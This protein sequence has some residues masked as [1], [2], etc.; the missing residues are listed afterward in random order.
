MQ[1]RTAT[2]CFK[3]FLPFAALIL[4]I[5]GLAGTS[6]PAQR[7]LKRHAIPQSLRGMLIPGT[8]DVQ[9]IVEL[10]DP[11]VLDRLQGTAP[12][13][14][15]QGNLPL[16]ARG[17]KVDFST[18]MARTHRGAVSRGQESMKVKIA[19]IPD[20][21]I[22]GTTSALM[23][24]VIIR[25]PAAQYDAVRNITGIKKVYF[26]LPRKPLLDTAATLQRAQA[27]WT[28]AG[29]KSS[30]G[31]G[32]RIGIL[33][34][35]IDITSPM[36]SGTGMTAPSG[37]P[38]Y[39]P[40]TNLPF[41]NAKV[42]VA[43]S[44]SSLF[45]SSSG[46]QTVEDELGHGTFVASCAAGV[47]VNAPK[48]V[49]SGMAPGAYLGVYKILSTSSTSSAAEIAALDD[50]ILDGMDVI[51]M[52]IGA[53][54]HLPPDEIVEYVALRKAIQ[55][56]VVVTISAG[57]EGASTHTISSPA[58]IPDVIAVGSVTNSRAF[59][60]V[61][62]TNAPSLTTIGYTPSD[63]TPVTSDQALKKIVDVAS[64]DADG[65]GCAAFSSG[66]LTGSIA[67]IQRGICNF[68]V[69]VGN[70]A[71]AGAVGVVVY[72]N[73]VG[74]SFEMSG[75]SLATI[76]A[77]MI[78]LSDGSAL[79]TYIDAN[80]STATAGIGSSTNILAV[81]VS[82]GIISDFSSVGP[83]PDFSIKP[84]LVAVGENVYAATQKTQPSGG[85]YDSTGFIT[86]DGT[87]FSSPMVAG[88][89]AGLIQKFPL[90][91]SLA[92]KSLLTTTASRN[93]TVDG[94][95]PP[96]VLQA[97]SGLLD[98]G[99]AMSATAV[100]SPTNLNYGVHAYS[101]TLSLPLVLTVQNISSSADQFIFGFEPLVSGP[102]ITFSSSSTG[103]IGAGNS[104]TVTVTLQ[105]TAPS[106]GGFQGFITARST[107]TSFV[108]RIPYWA[109]L[110]VSDPTRILEVSQSGTGS[111]STLADALVAA[112]PGNVIEIGDSSTYPISSPGLL[113]VTN[114][115]GLPLHG[116]TI[117]AASG[118]TPILQAP[119]L[120]VGLQIVGVQ[121]VLLQGLQVT[122]G[123][124]NIEPWQPS[125]SI[126]LSATIDRCTV[127]NAAVA[128]I[129]I[130]GG[131]KVDIT[132]S[133]IKQ[134]SGYGIAAGMF[135]DNTQLTVTGTTIQE[136]GYDG[137]DALFSDVF[138]ANSTFIENSGAGAYLYQS[139]GS[140]SDNTFSQNRD[141]YELWGD[142]LQIEDGDIT[143][144][145]N[146]FI[147]NDQSG[148]A[149][150]SNGS[151]ATA[152]IIGN[153][154]Q[155]NGFYGIFSYPALSVLADGNLIADNVGGVDLYATT[156]AI[157]TNNVI[158][159]SSGAR[160]GD[161]VLVEGGGTARLVNN[162][163]YQ[164]RSYGVNRSLG[165][166]TIA[167]SIISSNT[168]GN[169]LGID[170][171]SI[172][173]ST[174]AADPKF[175]NANSNDFSLATGSPA[176]DAGSNSA[177][178]LPFLDYNGQLRVA[179]AS[180][181]PGQGTV[182]AGAVESSSAYPLI[183]PLLLTGSN[184][185]IGSSFDTGIAFLNPTGASQDFAFA[186]FDPTG[187]K[188]SGTSNPYQ[189]SSPLNPN[190]QMPILDWQMFG[191]NA[192]D[193]VRG[194]VLGTADIPT[195]GFL[196]YSD[197]EAKKFATGVNAATNLSGSLVFM[198]H[199][200]GA[201][202][203]SSYIIFNPGVNVANITARLYSADGSNVS[204]QTATIAA[205]AQTIVQFN[206]TTTTG[207][208]TVSTSPSVPISG[209]ELVGTSNV[210]AALGGFSPG[211][212]AR[213]FF[214]H[215]AVGGNYSTQVGIINT[216]TSATA[217]LT[218]SAYDSAGK[219]IG[220][221]DSLT[222]QPGG[223]LL[224]T[225][226]ELFGLS[227]DGAL[228]TGYLVAQGDQ[229][230]LMGFTDFSYSD[231]V[232]VSDA[233][234][235]ADSSPSRRLLFSQIANGVPA[236]NGV[237][238]QTGIALLNPYGTSVEFTMSVYAGDGTLKYQGT[239][240]IGPHEKMS[241]MLVYPEAGFGF[242]T[243]DLVLGN[244]HVEVTS[245]LG[246]L[247]LEVFFTEDLSQMVSVPAQTIE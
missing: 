103:S 30:T 59:M 188:L 98:M 130:D 32:V 230:G 218:L 23:N 10:P 234:I 212:Q 233:T 208:A 168:L 62:R 148:V 39:A 21:K 159:R 242:F 247:G 80:P 119:S 126:P 173:S 37:F 193:T 35:G 140:I 7:D 22:L 52:S 179:S 222:L 77:A 158:V 110:Y 63:G 149:L 127:S 144:Q 143:V 240:T 41:T 120:A 214:P 94:T 42:I 172:T 164:N 147:S 229:A 200:T 221:V 105:S 76:P 27:M 186:G 244:G 31:Q 112:Q 204:T 49:I 15:N 215:Y 20:A 243:G 183:Y 2:V 174:T 5:A 17:R 104:A 195:A 40:T 217:T 114:G 138:I 72:N 206:S 190:G 241:K 133:I 71:N 25:V 128:N 66:S 187:A 124:I 43:R 51:N 26:S 145:S 57:N 64:L 175:V 176:I 220:S 205:K 74:G 163:I 213:L 33:D 137:L 227:S 97:G 34:S 58:S 107:T 228:Q 170:A 216:N 102:S 226:T 11:S 16:S 139:T 150:L 129:L 196:V 50:A 169:T 96:S 70:A 99:A 209:V 46:I 44:Y 88:A 122:G 4:W 180:L 8:E 165:T 238:Y 86:K 75:L 116:L 53:L 9:L 181:F 121:N 194:S 131:G 109:G 161:G 67:L 191:Y 141:S 177:S 232:A 65:L 36:F 28:A 100:F 135:A 91:G 171:G 93:L 189:P 231:G 108:Y 237:P 246:L 14:M 19:A 142:G 160:Y 106:T 60:P 223:L 207:Y 153:Q 47:E 90:L 154:M 69:K 219:M 225:I 162:T 29:G 38:H 178:D 54:D 92:I 3:G 117:R 78:S 125:A 87:S 73:L 167:N 81:N 185:A 13:G 56:G 79:K 134:S 113:V 155:S 55:A 18:A 245:E 202:R 166:V 123:Y 48:A 156:N 182:D 132:K 199:Q 68:S 95:N 12:S 111:Y 89:A 236:G 83:G 82:G 197:P 61:V 192:S 239:Q 152:K 210:M 157:L 115:Q 235:P 24:T 45:S 84:D 6:F 211:T 151:G 184:A 201:G 1:P 198:R 224:K 203:T 101:G 118:A 146:L 85:M 136:N